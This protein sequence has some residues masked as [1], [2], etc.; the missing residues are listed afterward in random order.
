MG[1]ETEGR[2]KKGR[3]SGR[4]MGREREGMEGRSVGCAK[5]GITI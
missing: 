1:R 5:L 4:E 3:N 2:E